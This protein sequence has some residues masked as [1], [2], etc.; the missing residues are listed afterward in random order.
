MS[1]KSR[2]YFYASFTITGEVLNINLISGLEEIFYKKFS[3]AVPI[4]EIK[5]FDRPIHVKE[6][7]NKLIFINDTQYWGIF[8]KQSLKLIDAKDYNTIISYSEKKRV[9]V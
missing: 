6:L 4:G 9:V 8:F 5:I 1:G 2:G 7:L 3:F